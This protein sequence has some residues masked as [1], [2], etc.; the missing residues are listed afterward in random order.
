MLSSR[1]CPAVISLS[2]CFL[3][4]TLWLSAAVELNKVKT[5][6]WRIHSVERGDI[7]DEN[8]NCHRS[9]VCR[10]KL[11]LQCEVFS[12][13]LMNI[14]VFISLFLCA[15]LVLSFAVT[16]KATSNEMWFQNTERQNIRGDNQFK[17]SIWRVRKQPRYYVYCWCRLVVITVCRRKVMPSELC[18]LKRKKKWLHQVKTKGAGT[19]ALWAK[20]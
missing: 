5:V 7:S 11:K 3:T 16:L 20:C 17:K 18:M 10:C 13:K 19:A 2:L 4:L 6:Y 12:N 14:Y 15:T 9:A 1:T 8:D